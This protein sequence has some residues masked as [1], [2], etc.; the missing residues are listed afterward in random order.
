MMRRVRTVD[1]PPICIPGVLDSLGTVLLRDIIHG[2]AQKLLVGGVSDP[3]D[4]LR[5]TTRCDAARNRRRRRL[6]QFLF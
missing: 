6:P 1:R 3:D 2:F 5:T 4:L